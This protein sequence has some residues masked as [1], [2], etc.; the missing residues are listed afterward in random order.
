MST[1]IAPTVVPGQPRRLFLLE[2]FWPGVTPALA[3]E[4]AR[5]LG[6]VAAE[7]GGPNAPVL[8]V[9]GLLLE[10]DVV[11]SLLEARSEAAARELTGRADF[12]VDRISESALVGQSG[13]EPCK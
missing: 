4:A 10:D 8:L 3:E 7:Q 6:R 9:S 11:F 5:G 2:R 13:T 1:P 12:Q